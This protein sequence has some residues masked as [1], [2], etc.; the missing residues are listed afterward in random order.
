VT[1]SSWV[2]SVWSLRGVD[3]PVVGQV[4]A[5]DGDILTLVMVG[6]GDA[7]L[8]GVEVVPSETGGRP[9]ARVSSDTLLGRWKRLGRAAA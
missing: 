1:F 2:G 7:P 9:L 5:V 8:E 3:G 6:L 4:H